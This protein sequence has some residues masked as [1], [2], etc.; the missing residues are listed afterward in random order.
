MDAAF[1]LNLIDF[2][3][4]QMA[5]E[6]PRF[7]RAF[8]STFYLHKRAPECCGSRIDWGRAFAAS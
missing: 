1:F 4:V 6:A 7:D 8:P 2:D 3:D 5:I